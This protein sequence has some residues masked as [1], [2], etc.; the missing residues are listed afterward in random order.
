MK[1]ALQKFS[2]EYLENCKKLDPISIIKFLE[3]F[4]TLHLKELT[5][6]KSKLIS[7]KVPE[8]LLSTFKVKAKLTGIPYQSQIKKLMEEWLQE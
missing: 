7:M 6:K 5:P 8:N 2:D 4:R 3:D 1:K